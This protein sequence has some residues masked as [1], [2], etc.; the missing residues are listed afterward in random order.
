MDA[1]TT[2]APG[3]R[4]ALIVRACEESTSTDPL[5]VFEKVASLPFVRMHGPEHHVLDGACLLAA[6]RNAGGKI[7]LDAALAE[8]ASRG[9]KMPGAMCGMWGA[10]GSTTSVGAALSIIEGTGPLTTD[11]SWGGHLAASSQA[12]LKMAE[13]G[14]PRCCKRDAYISLRE[15][16]RYVRDSLGIELGWHEPRCKFHQHNAQCLGERCPF[17]PL[18]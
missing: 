16:V 10:C 3:E 6:Y 7:D 4:E 12:L 13:V 2:Y 9:L 17:F 15:G 14:G 5:E 1:M 8:L 11:E 18:A